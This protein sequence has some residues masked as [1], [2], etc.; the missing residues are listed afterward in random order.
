MLQIGSAVKF[1]KKGDIVGYGWNTDCCMRCSNCITGNDP[2]CE[3]G[4]TATIVG[5]HGGWSDRIRV[6]STLAVLLP[7]GF[8]PAEAAPMTC[9]GVTVYN[10]L[11]RYI[12]KP[13]MKVAVVAIGG[14]GHIA[15]QFARAL[16]AKVTAVSHG[17]SKKEAALKLGA[18]EFLTT[19]EMIKSKAN[20]FDVIRSTQ[21]RGLDYAGAV[22]ALGYDGTLVLAS[23]HG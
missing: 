23:G 18:H 8:D 16:G 7:E 11:S 21:P 5:H 3:K 12:N 19:E 2:I 1:V 4:P 15:I 17:S 14:L 22:N 9:A 20:T 6:P 13:A 10:P